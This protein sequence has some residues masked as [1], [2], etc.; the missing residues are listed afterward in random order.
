[1]ARSPKS[2]TT[3]PRDA[4]GNTYPALFASL[5]S[6]ATET[7]FPW[8]PTVSENRHA[9]RPDES[10]R[11][12]LAFSAVVPK[13]GA[14]SSFVRR[15]HGAGSAVDASP[16]DAGERAAVVVGTP[17]VKAAIAKYKGWVTGTSVSL[18]TKIHAGGL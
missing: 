16:P 1:M 12:A 18:S 9:A 11:R 3:F 2:E 4:S 7:P 14:T 13:N 10:G 5:R 15:V 6:V 8:L 17:E